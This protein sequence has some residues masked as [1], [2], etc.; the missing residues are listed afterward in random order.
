MAAYPA[1]GGRAGRA[2]G[3]DGCCAAERGGAAVGGVRG[4]PAGAAEGAGVSAGDGASGAQASDCSKRLPA[5][6]AGSAPPALSPKPTH[7]AEAGAAAGGTAG[8]AETAADGVASKPTQ[9]LDA[10]VQPD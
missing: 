1:G 2:A 9:P 8:K 7:D 4:G 10:A 6:V 5:G 3:A